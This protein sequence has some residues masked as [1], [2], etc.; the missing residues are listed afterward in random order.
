MKNQSVDMDT[1]RITMLTMEE[2]EELFLDIKNK[3]FKDHPYTKLV[4]VKGLYH[5]V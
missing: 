3:H 5:K 2:F 4:S 1:P